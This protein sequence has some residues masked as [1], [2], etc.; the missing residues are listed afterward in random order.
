M[1][2]QNLGR[3]TKSKYFMLFS[4][5]AYWPISFIYVSKPLITSI[6]SIMSIFTI[7]EVFLVRW[8][9]YFYHQE[10]GRHLRL[11]CAS[12]WRDFDVSQRS[13]RNFII[14][15]STDRWERTVGDFLNW[16]ET[17]ACL[18]KVTMQGHKWRVSSLT[19]WNRRQQ[20]LS[21]AVVSCGIPTLSNDT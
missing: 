19:K 21:E 9:V 18:L 2:M 10:E 17:K 7:T 13:W 16:S 11:I 20:I 1:L 6:T 3:Q 4:E 8:L 5:M 12:R 14:C 15:K